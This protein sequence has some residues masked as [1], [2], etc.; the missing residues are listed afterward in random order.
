MPKS[1]KTI[2]YVEDE[3][4]IMGGVIDSLANDY[5]VLKAKN[6]DQA[7]AI[8]ENNQSIDLIILDIMMPPGTR[9][10]NSHKGKTTGVE[11]ARI[12]IDELKSHVPIICYTVV[13]DPAVA[14]ELM[15]LGIKEIISKKE[16]PSELE[17]VIKKYI[18]GI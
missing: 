14:A 11:L 1:K 16:L 2:L 7:L 12:I 9:V 17:V 18:K 8:V 5:T 13:N 4:W 10:Q 15:K 3:Q 6:A